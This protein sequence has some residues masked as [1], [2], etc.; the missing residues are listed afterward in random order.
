MGTTVYTCLTLAQFVGIVLPLISIII[1]LSKEQNSVSSNLMMA[2]VGCL[3][4]NSCYSFVMRASDTLEAYQT[5][6]IMYLGNVMMMYFF[7]RFL[8]AYFHVKKADVFFSIWLLLDI[9]GVVLFWNDSTAFLVYKNIDIVHHPE[10]GVSFLHYDYGVFYIFR[11]FAILYVYIFGLVMTFRYARKCRMESEKRSIRY[12]VNSQLIMITAMIIYGIF[13]FEY[14]I[15]T[16]FSALGMFI[17][18]ISLIKESFYSISDF[19]QNKTFEYVNDAVIVV[20]GIYGFQSCNNKAVQLFPELKKV[21]RNDRISKDME[22][23]LLNNKDDVLIG[24]R[25]YK[26]EKSDYYDGAQTIGHVFFLSDN[27]ERHDLIEQIKAEKEKAEIAN[28]AK[29]AFVAN[30]SHEIRTPMNAVVGMTEIL[31]RYPHSEQEQGYLMNIKN[32]GAALI[33]IIN[34]ILDLS[35]IES[36]KMQLVED[37]YEPLSMLN[38]LGMIFLNRIGEKN[39]ELIYEISPQL[40]SK[41]YG[42][43][44]RLRQ[45]I[46]NIVN[47]AIKYTDSGYVRVRLEVN[48]LNDAETEI[49][50][51][52]KDT[53]QGIKPEDMTKIFD[54]FSRVD[55]KKNRYKEGTGLGLSIAQRLIG[56]MDGRITATSEYGVGSEFVFS[57]KQKVIDSSPATMVK[58]RDGGAISASAC[59]NDARLLSSLIRLTK[60]YNLS[61]IGYESLK[62]G[63]RKVDY[64]FA[65]VAS[66]N[67]YKDTMLAMLNEGG[68][69]CVLQNPMLDNVSDPDVYV[70]DKPLYSLNFCRTLNNE[71][72]R[73]N[74]I[75]KDYASFIAPDARILVVDDMEMNLKVAVGV[76]GPLQMSID[77]ADSGEKAIELVSE[78]R[79]DVIF[80]DHMMPVMDGIEATKAIRS[81][82]GDYY[83]NVPIIAFSA[84]VGMDAVNTFKNAGMNDFVAK[85]IELKEMF[86][87]L[88]HWLPKELIVKGGDEQYTDAMKKAINIDIPDIEG[89]DVYEGVK[90]SGGQELFLSLLGDFYKLIDIKCT[91]IEKCLADNLIH[92]YTIEVHGLKNTARMIGAMELSEDFKRMEKL[93]NDGAVEDI[94]RQTP[95]VL[96][97]FRSYKKILEPFGKANDDEKED[98]SKEELAELLKQLGDA[99]DN[100]DLDMADSVMKR[101]DAVKIPENQRELYENL[102]AYVADVAM[103]EVMSTTKEMLRR[104]YE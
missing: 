68:R 24:D 6:R 102:R 48:S 39:I 22:D 70:I 86:A 57:F 55:S 19:G 81:M 51:S 3:I 78:N 88:Y 56:M 27:Q 69:L 26:I 23:L 76:L 28:N 18:V 65:D 63:V 80:M 96:A 83:K 45:V 13:R 8:I 38:D 60:E 71:D 37:T 101:L 11:M 91:K 32:S 100:F 74:V 7:A 84:N 95:D 61:Y 89:I 2:N 50:M 49:V 77:T 66:Y 97:L 5:V 47:N 34:D 14:D 12:L 62:H 52:V 92:D 16:L 40:P 10:Y 67:S 41:L 4:L 21:E 20:N 73:S 98:I 103:E 33:A 17:V 85:P 99:M 64:M 36:G 75:L 42:D 43:S 31:L 104:L 9:M 29:S 90:N 72:K 15:V 35:K 44:M 53:G 25:Y 30:M 59:F 58:E 94:K 46:I 82:E 93:G 79:Y 54:S 1:I 87:K